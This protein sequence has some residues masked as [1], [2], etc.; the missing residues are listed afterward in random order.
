MRWGPE[1]TRV[2]HAPDHTEGRLRLL[3]CDINFAT[4]SHRGVSLASDRFSCGFAGQRP[5]MKEGIEEH[6][7]FLMCP[8]IRSSADQT[9]SKGRTRTWGTCPS[10]QRQRVVFLTLNEADAVEW[11]RA[12]TVALFS[13]GLPPLRH[14]AKN[15]CVDRR[16]PERLRVSVS[17]H[18][19]TVQELSNSGILRTTK[20]TGSK[21]L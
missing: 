19:R 15:L 12:E 13:C 18:W 1:E 5:R 14:E 8:M 6:T 17:G 7:R 16:D 9:A 10:L 4:P 3:H 20:R 11:A 2:T 21:I